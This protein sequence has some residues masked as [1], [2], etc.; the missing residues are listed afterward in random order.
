VPAARYA[1]RPSPPAAGTP[2]RPAGCAWRARIDGATWSSRSAPGASTG[3]R[4]RTQA[5]DAGCHR[6]PEEGRLGGERGVCA[7][8]YLG[9]GEPISGGWAAT[10]RASCVTPKQ[11]S[12]GLNGSGPQP[13]ALPSPNSQRANAQWPDQ[14]P[15]AV[16]LSVPAPSTLGGPCTKVRKTAWKDLFQRSIP[17]ADRKA[18]PINPR[19]VAFY[20]GLPRRGPRHARESHEG[21][22]NFI[23]SISGE[24]VQTPREGEV[25]PILAWPTPTA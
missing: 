6:D 5:G 18:Q 21:I 23:N 7:N 17:T 8:A 16:S 19:N 11:R 24:D 15:G 13:K 3:A 25:F 2:T 4:R 20:V 1:G 22:A 14:F 10:L 12:A 9:F